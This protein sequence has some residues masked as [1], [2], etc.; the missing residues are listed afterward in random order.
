MGSGEQDGGIEK[1]ILEVRVAVKELLAE[2][3][4][5]LHI[6]KEHHMQRVVR[7]MRQSD[8]LHWDT[9]GMCAFRWAQ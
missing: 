9:S 6:C 8:S 5:V 4:R 3:W 2:K 1:C 7:Q